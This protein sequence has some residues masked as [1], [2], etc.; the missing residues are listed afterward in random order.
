MI[1]KLNWKHKA[2][3]FCCRLTGA[4][5]DT[6]SPVL[7][8]LY[9]FEAKAR[10]GDPD[11]ERVLDRAM[12]L[13]QAEPKLFEAIAGNYIT[14]QVLKYVDNRQYWNTDPAMLV[15]YIFLCIVF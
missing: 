4:E 15:I 7:L 8:L 6:T 10:L 12:C 5:N 2:I 11:A 9:E 13:P 1:I 14:V 3:A